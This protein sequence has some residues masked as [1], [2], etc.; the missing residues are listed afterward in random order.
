M[1]LPIIEKKANEFRSH[2]GLTPYDSIRLKSLL[3]KLNVLTVFKELPEA[4]SGMAIK[5]DSEGKT[6][7]FM[8]INANKSL[9]HQHFTICHELYH[10]FVQK[11]F[12]FMVCQVGNFNKKLKEEYNADA[13]ATCLL[14]PSAGIESLIPDEELG[15]DKITLKTLLKIE[16]YYSC[17]RTALLFRLK[18]LGF[19]SAEAV[20]PFKLNVQ[21]HAIQHGFTI[22][23]YQPG[24]KDQVIGD[25]G[26]IARE[27][28]DKELISESH[29][30]SLLLDLG[31]NVEEIENI[32]NEEIPANHID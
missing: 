10:L 2:L 28:F 13:F 3:S 7:R 9:G 26:T 20:E 30:Y 14:M 24:N 8:L 11:E 4:I 1:S 12:Q 17:S 21:R 19:L 5:V 25:Y 16:Q 15:K 6:R 22:D 23:L 29:Y 27:L 18:D 31:M 32:G